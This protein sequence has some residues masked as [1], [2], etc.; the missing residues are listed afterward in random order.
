MQEQQSRDSDEQAVQRARLSRRPSISRH[1][2]SHQ[3]GFQVYQE[4]QDTPNQINAIDAF[5][6]HELHKICN[7]SLLVFVC[8][9]AAKNGISVHRC[10]EGPATEGENALRALDL[11]EFVPLSAQGASELH[12]SAST[13]AVFLYLGKRS[14]DVV[15]I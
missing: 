5:V 2:Q 15:S 11:G 12:L 7:E 3:Q 8:D 6:V 10:R 9:S 14:T 1:R 4:R 13:L